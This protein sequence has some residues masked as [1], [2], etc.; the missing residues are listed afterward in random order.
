MTQP[1]GG[2]LAV[3]AHPDD[4][5]LCGAGTLALCAARGRPVTLV[6]ATRGEL[7]PI[8]DPSLATRDTLARV[9]ERELQASCA[10]LG[11]SDLRWL[12]LPDASVA[13][14]GEER[15]TLGVLV[16]LIRTLRPRVLITFGSDGLY[17][18]SD[19]VAIGELATEARRLAADPNVCPEQLSGACQVFHV[20]RLFYPVI[21]AQFVV[22]LLDALAAIGRRAQFWSVRPADFH[23]SSSAISASVDVTSVLEPKRAALHSH[24]TQL[25]AD[26][27]LRLLTPELEARF[28]GVEHFS[29]ADG[30]PG[31][32]VSG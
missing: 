26:N 8:A 27:A 1:V 29:C 14:T 31:D 15:G 20:P 17:G 28:L 22:D 10:A 19:H 18:H 11:V 25:E 32:P 9:R 21:T 16:Q 2:V 24:R 6:C 3:F 12:D 7:G 23:A 30:L 13:W 5:V 4:E